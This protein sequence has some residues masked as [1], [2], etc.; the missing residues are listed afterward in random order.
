MQ[1]KICSCV[2]LLIYQFKRHLV[3]D[4]FRPLLLF[5]VIDLILGP[6]Y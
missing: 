6:I 3:G 4:I 1:L 2:P 5:V